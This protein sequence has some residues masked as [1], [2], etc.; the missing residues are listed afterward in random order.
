M[1][2]SNSI[3]KPCWHVLLLSRA[4]KMVPT[5]IMCRVYCNHYRKCHITAQYITLMTPIVKWIIP[6][7]LNVR[8]KRA[9]LRA[10]KVTYVHGQLGCGSHDHTCGLTLQHTI[11]HFQL[12]LANT[13]RQRVKNRKT[14]KKG[15]TK[16]LRK[17][18]L[19]SHIITGI[20]ETW[21]GYQENPTGGQ[22]VQSCKLGYRFTYLKT[23]RQKCSD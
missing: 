16:R 20:E 10:I 17:P 22:F 5:C 12:P 6:G 15:M 14:G 2:G 7:W 3:K 13:W 9:Y 19:H 1:A 8:E 18:K 23:D 21:G 11:F 4:F